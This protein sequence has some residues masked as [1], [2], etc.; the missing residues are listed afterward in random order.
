M[1]QVPLGRCYDFVSRAISLR[2]GRSKTRHG[3]FVALS[4]SGKAEELR[5]REAQSIVAV[6]VRAGAKCSGTDSDET[7]CEQHPEAR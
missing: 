2:F 4:K 6:H 5:A 3:K 7:T 1:F